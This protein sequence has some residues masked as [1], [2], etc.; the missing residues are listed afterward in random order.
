MAIRTDRAPRSETWGDDRIA[1]EL[2]R[3]VAMTLAIIV[4]P[5]LVAAVLMVGIYMALDWV[6][7]RVDA[8]VHRD[9]Q[10]LRRPIW[11]RFRSGSLSV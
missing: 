3:L 10:R 7:L 6:V 9:F 1:S 11:G 4:T 2:V 8:L 5:L